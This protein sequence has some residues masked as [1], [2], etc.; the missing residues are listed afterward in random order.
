ME[1]GVQELL[2]EGRRV[3][4]RQRVNTMVGGEH[5]ATEDF[6][7]LGNGTGLLL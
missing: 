6:L 4:L 2:A 1:Y 7:T 3:G 5:G